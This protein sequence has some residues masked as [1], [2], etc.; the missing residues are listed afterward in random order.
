MQLLLFLLFHLQI[1]HIREQKEGISVLGIVKV[2]VTLFFLLELSIPFTA[3]SSMNCRRHDNL[4]G[5]L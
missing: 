1:L 2:T 4:V 5:L 3:S